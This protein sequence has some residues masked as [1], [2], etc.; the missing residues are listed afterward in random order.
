MDATVRKV[1]NL[2]K[3][4]D[5]LLLDGRKKCWIYEYGVLPYLC[6]DFAMVEINTTAMEKM[7]AIVTRHLKK[8]LKLTKSANPSILY[9]GTCGL[10][11]TN[12]KNAITASRCNTEIILCTSKDP[13]VRRIAKR[14]R[15][16]ELNSPVQNVPKRLKTAVRDLE[17][18]KAFHSHTRSAHDRRGFGS[19]GDTTVRVNKKSIVGRVKELQD[20]E[21]TAKIMSLAVQSKWTLWDELIEVDLKW[22]EFMYGFSPSLLSFWLNSIQDTLPDP[23][24]L[25][26]WGKQLLADCGLCKWKNCTLQHIICSCRVALEQGRISFRHDSILG[27]IVQGIKEKLLEEKKLGPQKGV[28]CPKPGRKLIQFVKKGTKVVRRKTRKRSSF[29]GG[30]VDWKVLE[31]TRL[32][33]YQIPPSIASSALRPDICLYSE[34]AKKVCF[35]ELTSPAEEN[36]QLWKVTKREKYIDLV[37]E[38]KANGYT[39]L[40]RTIEVGARGF[41]SKSSMNVFSILGFS[42]KKRNELKKTM[43]KVAIRCSHFIWINRNNP[44]W[45]SPNRVL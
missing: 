33:Q 27:C 37:E 30:F 18:Q 8:W 21:T 44:S 4:T 38:A 12:I 17:F 13:T 10:S 25:R 39:A 35:I 5:D 24:N 2:M 43:S 32:K 7:E 42:Q 19:P 20:E 9:R 34:K 15:E 40:C 3:K 31:D 16:E 36:I 14:R 6:W 22:N 29:W 45:S 23:V 26:R 41:V 11:I 1:V 28:T